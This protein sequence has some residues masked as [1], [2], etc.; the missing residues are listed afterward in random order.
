MKNQK[1]KD[2]LKTSKKSIVKKVE[3]PKNFTKKK[4]SLVW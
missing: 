1:N 3:N 4:Y 2:K